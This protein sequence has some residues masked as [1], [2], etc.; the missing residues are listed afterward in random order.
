MTAA[1]SP[2][3]DPPYPAAPGE[4][5]GAK[6]HAPTAALRAVH[7][8]FDAIAPATWDELASANPWATPFSRWGVQRA[9][10]DAYAANAHDQ[11]LVVVDGA[12]SDDA[13]PVAIVPL[14]H[15]HEVEP[16]RTPAV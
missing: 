6:T 15:R 1:I 10:W 12:A 7:R 13:P 14:M 4:S 11:T 5:P 2:D 16:D 8:P 3:L 9:W